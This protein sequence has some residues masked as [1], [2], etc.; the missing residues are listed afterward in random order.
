M[1]NKKLIFGCVTLAALVAVIIAMFVPYI[2]V[3]MKATALGE[4]ISESQTYSIF[5]G[6]LLDAEGVAWLTIS[7]IALIVLAVA[8]LVAGLVMIYSSLGKK[9]PDWVNLVGV[10][11]GLVAV[12][13]TIVL[14]GGMIGFGSANRSVQTVGE[15]VG[16]IKVW[17]TVGFWLAFVGGAV[18]SVFAVLPYF[19]KK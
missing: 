14:A 5:N 10:I 19:K 3:S 1:K 17:G 18:A 6:D 8:L 11:A 7:K 4:T 12:V 2:K 13:A 15:T 16:S 9:T